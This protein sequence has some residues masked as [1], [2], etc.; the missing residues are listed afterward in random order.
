MELN[1]PISVLIENFVKVYIGMNNNRFF[2][3][4]VETECV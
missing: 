3:L 2:Q 1:K 4:G